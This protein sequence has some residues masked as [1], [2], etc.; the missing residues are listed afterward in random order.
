MGTRF[1]VGLT[2]LTTLL[3]H[4]QMTAESLV[5]DSVIP[6]RTSD[7]GDDALSMMS[8]FY[9]RHLP[10]VNNTQL[11]GI[12]CEEDILNSD[13]EEPVGSYQLSL[14]HVKVLAGDH[15]YE[16]MRV[17]ADF[18]LTVVPVVDPQGNYIGLI[19]LEDLLHFFASSNTF[20]ETGSII[21]LEMARRDYSLVEIARIVESE[22][23]YILSSFISSQADPAIFNVT[24]KINSQDIYAILNTFERFNYQIKA[25]FNESVYH[26]ALQDRY[27]A[28]INYLNV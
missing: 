11:L 16:V 25:S 26:E 1:L 19:T 12:L 10:V 15:I 20:Q 13:V 17:L 2:L 27:D 23:S 21:V 6:L 7:T 5:S 8:D 28:L 9:I 18:K 3:Y 22:G 4:N 24:I 14:P